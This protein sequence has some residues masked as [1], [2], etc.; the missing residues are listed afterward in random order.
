MV[1]LGT[2]KLGR[3]TGLQSSAQNAADA[4]ALSAAYDV[5][6]SKLSQACR[7]ARSAAEKNEAHVVSCE[8]THNDVVVSVSMNIDSQFRAQARAEIE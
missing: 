4:A 5:A 2:A 8:V 7:S 6:H 1:A 3:A